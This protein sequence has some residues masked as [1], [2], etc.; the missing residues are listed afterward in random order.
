MDY[1]RSL[2]GSIDWS[3]LAPAL[4][5]IVVIILI[6]AL[7]GILLGKLLRRIEAALVQRGVAEGEVLTES[8]KRAHTLMRLARQALMLIIWLL[9]GL[10]ILREAGVEI[11]PLLAGAG[12]AGLA[13]GF[14]A[15]NLVR[16]FL[17]GF[18]LVLENQVR[19]GDAVRVN[20]TWGFVEEL[21]FRILVLRDLT[22]EVHIF[23][24]GSITTLSNMS[25]EWS[26]YLFELGVAYKEHTDKVTAV[27]QEVGA[28]LRANPDFGQHILQDIEVFGVDQF[29]DSAVVIKGRIKTKP[30]KQW[31][32][33]R[34]FNRRIKLAFDA[35]G[36]EI[37]FP[38]RTLYFGE[39][40]RPFALLKAD[41]HGGPEAKTGSENS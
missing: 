16:D 13:L 25:H 6:A 41:A 23:P 2:W 38:H 5:R 37:P 18:F 28:D 27:I 15:Q 4:T 31:V 34:E 21:N 30:L 22:G 26:A 29:A 40:S 36:I 35:R 7:A 11:G 32:V 33:G 9:A 39:A 19:V 3:S 12:I 10:I 20:G 1:L 8:R 17:A 14:G 24:N